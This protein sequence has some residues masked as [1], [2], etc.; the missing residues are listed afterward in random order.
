MS[1]GRIDEVELRFS[2]CLSKSMALLL[3]IAVFLGC[4][5]IPIIKGNWYGWVGYDFVGNSR[6]KCLLEE[7]YLSTISSLDYVSLIKE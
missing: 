5:F 4:S 3:I 7:V 6:I 1:I 2:L